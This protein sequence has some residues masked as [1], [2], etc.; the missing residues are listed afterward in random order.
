[1]HHVEQELI[2]SGWWNTGNARRGPSCPPRLLLCTFT[3]ES[4][5]D[6]PPEQAAAVV[7][8]GRAHVVVNFEAM[9]HVNV[10]TFLLK[11][12]TGRGVKHF[13]QNRTY[14]LQKTA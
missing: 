1:M 14:F 2:S 8:E 11:L 10:E 5:F 12:R 9:R 7:T 4:L 13:T 3:F 6:Q